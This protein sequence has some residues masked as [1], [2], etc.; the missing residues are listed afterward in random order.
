MYFPVVPRQDQEGQGKSQPVSLHITQLLFHLVCRE[1][2]T[3][4]SYWTWHLVS[5][6]GS[7]Q[8]ACSSASKF[9]LCT[10]A[11]GTEIGTF[12]CWTPWGFCW[13][14]FSSS[15]AS[16]LCQCLCQQCLCPLQAQYCGHTGWHGPACQHPPL[17][18]K[19]LKD[20]VLLLP[21][22]WL[23]FYN[24][25]IKSQI[26]TLGALLWRWF[27]AQQV[28][29][30]PNPCVLTY[31][32]SRLRDMVPKASINQ[33]VSHLVTLLFSTDSHFIWQTVRLAL[34]VNP[35]CSWRSSGLSYAWK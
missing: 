29:H 12:S 23:Y 8:Q 27:P 5:F 24:I 1:P 26:A 16:K 7:F 35:C 14:D 31:Q 2:H 25:P 4:G 30:S 19:T 3:V 32:T 15:S 6:P 21:S 10:N 9:L 33:S 34:H 17:W 20:S 11:P 18:M 22:K 28:V 13:N